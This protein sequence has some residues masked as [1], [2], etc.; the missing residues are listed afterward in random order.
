MVE[1]LIEA[2][3]NEVFPW[4]NEDHG[5]RWLLLLLTGY[6]SE[7]FCEEKTD[8]EKP[9]DLSWIDQPWTEMENVE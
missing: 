9:I 3:D 8:D 2:V 7:T 5:D 4:E 6:N 1:A